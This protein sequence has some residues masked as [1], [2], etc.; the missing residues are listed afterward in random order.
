[1]FEEFSDP[2]YCINRNLFRQIDFS[3]QSGEQTINLVWIRSDLCI[4]I[5]ENNRGKL[6]ASS[7][8]LARLTPGKTWPPVL[9]S[10]PD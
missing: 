1:L 6:H 3:S 10:R 4:A 9:P 5:K 7:E 8:S 2:W